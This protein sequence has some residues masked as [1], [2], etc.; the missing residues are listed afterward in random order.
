MM[1]EQQ[2]RTRFTPD[3][4]RSPGTT[5]A[6]ALDELGYTQAAVANRAGISRKHLNQIIKG[7]AALSPDTAL[8]LEKVTGISAA[9]WN[10]LEAHYREHLS[11]MQEES[12]F[13]GDVTWLDELPV[14]ELIRRGWI[15]K[16]RDKVDQ[17][18]EVLRFFGVADRSAWET[19]WQKPTAYRR[20]PAFT[21]HPGA[22]AA[23][24]RYGEIQAQEIECAPFDRSRF[25]QA[26][27][28][29][30]AATRLTQPQWTSALV[31]VCA[32]AG[33]A[34]VIEPEVQGASINGAVRW[35]TPEKALIQLSG[36]Y[37]RADFLWFTFFHEAGHLLLHGKRETFIDMDDGDTDDIERAAEAFAAR[38]L[39]PDEYEAELDELN[40][41]ADIVAFADE[42]GI[43]P[44][45]VAGRLQRE[46]DQYNKWPSLIQRLVF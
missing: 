24:L 10:G 6:A 15:E 38:T 41:A 18:R 9:M 46:R 34:V 14:A 5:L 19:V 40:T 2:A 43:H 17:L 36:R 13:A 8:R 44:G 20:S 4:A 42:I 30:R 28:E 7:S 29:L 16:C 33:V 31:S 12:E 26:L 45:I 21:S 22:V 25:R 39:I 1:G 32:E 23:W 27:S 37:H 35:L 3:Y 11:R